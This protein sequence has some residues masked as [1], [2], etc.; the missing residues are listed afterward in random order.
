MNPERLSASQDP[1]RTSHLAI[2]SLAR[3]VDALIEVRWRGVLNQFRPRLEALF[4]R[5]STRAYNAYL[6]IVLRPAADRL[7][8]SGLVAYPRMPG[9]I[10]AARQVPACDGSHNEQWL[11][12]TVCTD[13]DTSVGSLVTVLRTAS[14]RFDVIRRPFVF[15]TALVRFQDVQAMGAAH[16]QVSRTPQRA[17]HEFDLAEP[18]NLVLAGPRGSG[19]AIH[20]SPG[21]GRMEQQ[22]S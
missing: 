11:S 9:S 4:R 21:T 5:S 19:P 15:G 20:T 13:T 7:V 10:A 1:E 14:H 22:Q 16:F 8:R 2:E 18:V 12:I 6:W 3:S 17:T